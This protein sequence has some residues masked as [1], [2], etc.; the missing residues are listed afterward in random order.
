MQC[1]LR[2][3]KRLQNHCCVFSLVFILKCFVFCILGWVL[4]QSS[5]G[6]LYC[7]NL[8]VSC[9]LY[10]VICALFDFSLVDALLWAISHCIWPVSCVLYSWFS[11]LCVLCSIS[12]VFVFVLNSE[13]HLLFSVYILCSTFYVAKLNF[14]FNYNKL[15]LV[16]ILFYLT[17]HP[18]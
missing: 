2:K 4:W 12:V 8:H 15:R 1:L 17:T 6:A 5:F 3:G 18:D 11:L 13:L 16:L 10:P 9:V 7:V 14:N